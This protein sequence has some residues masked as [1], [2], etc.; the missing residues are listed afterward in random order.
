M[1][2]WIVWYVKSLPQSLVFL[3]LMFFVLPQ[4]WIIQEMILMELL[5][6]P[7]L[8]VVSPSCVRIERW[9]M[10]RC[11]PC[12]YHGLTACSKVTADHGP[13]VSGCASKWCMW[14][15][16][17][18][19]HCKTVQSVKG[20][21][22]NLVYQYLTKLQMLFG[23]L[24]R[25]GVFP[26]RLQHDQHRNQSLLNSPIKKTHKLTE[27]T[28]NH[29]SNNYFLR[30]WLCG[31]STC[32]FSWQEPLHLYVISRRWS[33]G[34][35]QSFASC[36]EVANHPTNVNGVPN[37]WKPNDIAFGFQLF[38]T[39]WRCLH[40]WG[41]FFPLQDF[42]EPYGPVWEIS[43]AS[44]GQCVFLFIGNR[45]KDWERMCVLTSLF[46]MIFL[47]QLHGA[48]RNSAWEFPGTFA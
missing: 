10:V 39:L 8:W 15:A 20:Q 4:R 9:A 29:L 34:R 35:S 22:L 36:R 40:A 48:T 26:S 17:Q 30:C 41:H 16:D 28:M 45:R 21:N 23:Y 6:S 42:V 43:K 24:R 46:Y 31:K 12:P 3:E 2:Y 1:A 32:A 44:C 37:S 18:H 38:G 13:A 14:S 33:T 5:P 11:H 27:I 25:C 19:G 47:V 7:S